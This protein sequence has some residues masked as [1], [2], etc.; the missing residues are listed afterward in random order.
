MAIKFAASTIGGGALERTGQARSF[1]KTRRLVNAGPAGRPK[2]T[3]PVVQME[4]Q[5]A[6]HSA[7]AALQFREL[8]GDAVRPCQTQGIHEAAASLAVGRS[9]HR[10]LFLPNGLLV[11]LCHK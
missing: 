10:K 5:I 9:R 3:I 7:C 8:A 2:A 11:L 1:W 6:Q 4:E